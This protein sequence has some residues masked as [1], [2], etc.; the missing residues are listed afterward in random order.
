MKIAIASAPNIDIRAQAE[1]LGSKFKCAL[2]EDPARSLCRDMGFQT[3]YDIPVADQLEIRLQLMKMHGEQ[4]KLGGGVH[5]TSV[6]DMLADWARWMWS[7]TTAE[8]WE[9]VLATARKIATDYDTI[10]WIKTGPALGYNGYDWL[11]QRNATQIDAL[12][13]FI[14]NQA[15]V[16]EKLKVIE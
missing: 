7:H 13:P 3:L 8:K 1:Q 11:D 9:S 15:G 5:M 4:L 10:Y 12:I 6:V 14:A 2:F 16:S